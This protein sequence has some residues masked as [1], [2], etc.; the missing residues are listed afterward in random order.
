VQIGNN[1]YWMLELDEPSVA[2]ETAL[3][4]HLWAR[5]RFLALTCIIGAGLA[6]AVAMMLPSKYS[7]VSR[8]VIEPPS[9]MDPRAS[10]AVSPI[11]LESLRSY[12]AYASS[13][14][15]FSR[16]AGQFGLRRGSEAIDNLKRSVLKVGMVRNTKILEIRVDWPDPRVAHQLAVYIADETVKLSQT[17]GRGGE[18]ESIGDVEKQVAEARERADKSSRA[19]A[20]AAQQGSVEQL[21]ARIE[22]DEHITRRQ[23]RG[24][25]VVTTVGAHHAENSLRR[26]HCFRQPVHAL[27]F[28][29][30]I[31]QIEVL[32]HALAIERRQR[33]RHMQRQS[34]TS[35]TPG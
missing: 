9:G 35:L 1:H 16:A 14:E 15:L 13:D 21:K 6:G 20:A 27:G 17:V 25:V 28:L 8:I 24:H 7:A 3:P 34:T 22:G 11:Y 30:Y 29:K 4:E 23:A 5:R 32:R 26:K 18:Q 2:G 10:V 19:S 12:E 31:L 33:T